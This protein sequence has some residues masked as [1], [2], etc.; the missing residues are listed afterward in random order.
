MPM[1]NVVRPVLREEGVRL[2]RRAFWILFV[3]IGLLLKEDLRLRR[4]HL[5]RHY[6]K[7]QSNRLD[8]QQ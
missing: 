7:V 2:A 5:R 6:L 3:V 1:P 4:H 8:M